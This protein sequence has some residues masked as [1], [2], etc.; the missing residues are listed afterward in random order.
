MKKGT[1]SLLASSSISI[2][3]IASAVFRKKWLVIASF[4]TAVV[5]AGLFAYLIPD[6]YESRMKI[7]VRNMRAEAPVT[8][9]TEAPVDRNEV[10][11]SQI[12]SEIELL[13]SRDLLEKLVKETNLVKTDAD[14]AENHQ[15]IEKAVFKLEK[16]LQITPI[17]KANIIEVSYAST[18][19]ETVALVL[20][21][22]S[23][24]YFDKHLQVHHPPGAYAF[25]KD[26]ADAYQ[27]ELR[28][29]EN[30][31]SAFQQQQNVVAIEQQKELI[32]TKMVE[33]N[34]KLQ[35]LNGAIQETDKRIT[36]L[37]NQ[38]DGMDRRVV[39]QSRT[40]PNQFSAERLNTMLVELKNRRIQLLA[41]FQ[42]T[43]RVVREVDDQI[44]GT[45]EALQKAVQSTAVE[46]A[47]DLNPLRQMLESDLTKA[48]VEQKGRLALRG[49]LSAQAGDY[50]KQLSKL[51]KATS[52]HND[53]S[54]QVKQSEGNY[55]LYAKKEEESRINDALDKQKISNV[56]VAEAP[57]VPR[58]PNKNNRLLALIFGLSLGLITGIGT[59]FVSELL[60]ETFITPQELEKYTGYSVLATL[61]IH[62]SNV[63][64]LD[65]GEIAEEFESDD[66][67]DFVDK[68]EETMFSH[69]YKSEGGIRNPIN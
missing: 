58:A 20:T 35:D 3:S 65:L 28:G 18:S 52:R 51:E 21:R 40:L 61:P 9:G 67:K 54:R 30:Q 29:S 2:R 49:N 33:A 55:Q 7:L 16:D 14:G 38:L 69:S 13:K 25:F 37:Q 68:Y 50:Q 62:H 1:Y 60:R 15:E 39:T 45:T 42:P 26:Q 48:K 34:S 17:K 27:K 36:E 11:E 41:K 46:Q 63:E 5:A 32:L 8:A 57:T 6:K 47:T 23:E 44:Q 59:A 64:E 22:L 66:F 4:A 19:P 56:S 53:L 24:L 12:V 31:L 43:D 10:S